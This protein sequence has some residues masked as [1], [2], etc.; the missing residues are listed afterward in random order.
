MC[1]TLRWT[2]FFKGA[3]IMRISW[4]FTLVIVTLLVSMSINAKVCEDSK[5]CQ[6]NQICSAKT[7]VASQAS[8]IT[9]AKLGVINCE[10]YLA[11]VNNFCQTVCYCKSNDECGIGQR[12]DDGLCVYDQFS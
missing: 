3:A 5:D 9:A 4:K 6:A 8:A 10:Q 2:L 12:C 11:C 1:F 7:C